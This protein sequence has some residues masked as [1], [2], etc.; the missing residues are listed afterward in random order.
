MKTSI[1]IGLF[2]LLLLYAA[3]VRAQTHVDVTTAASF[4]KGTSGAVLGLNV[5]FPQSD[6]LDIFTGTDLWGATDTVPNNWDW[7][8]GFEA[9]KPWFCASIGAGYLQRIDELNGSHAE[10]FLRLSHRFD[11]GRLHSVDVFHLSNAGTQFPNYGRNAAGVTW[12]LQ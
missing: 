5:I 7:H 12:R 11:W 8:L 9:C 4:G 1:A 2:V 6:N 10:Y 3:F